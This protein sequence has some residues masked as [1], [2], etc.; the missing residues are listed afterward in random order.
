MTNLASLFNVQTVAFVT[1]ARKDGPD[2]SSF[3]LQLEEDC[4]ARSDSIIPLS[5]ERFVQ[6]YITSI[7]KTREKM[8]ER[9]LPTKSSNEIKVAQNQSNQ[10][11]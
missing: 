2:T 11:S 10:L 6:R 5:V 8:P 1:Q 7:L 3:S 9:M 4:L